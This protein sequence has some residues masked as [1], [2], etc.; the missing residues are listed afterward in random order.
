MTFKP[1]RTPLLFLRLSLRCPFLATI[2]HMLSTL[3]GEQACLLLRRTTNWGVLSKGQFAQHKSFCFQPFERETGGHC[4]NNFALPL[5]TLWGQKCQVQ[6][7][8]RNRRICVKVLKLIIWDIVVYSILFCC[9]LL[10]S[11]LML[12]NG[13]FI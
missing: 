1:L 13:K 12:Y 6:A 10:C 5:K 4:G 8:H 2:T 7:S 11:S 9:T 3:R